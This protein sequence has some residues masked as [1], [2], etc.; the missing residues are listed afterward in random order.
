MCKSYSVK[1]LWTLWQKS[2]NHVC[3]TFLLHFVSFTDCSIVSVVQTYPPGVNRSDSTMK[4]LNLTHV[5]QM[6]K[7][8][9]KRK[10][11]SDIVPFAKRNSLSLQELIHVQCHIQINKADLN[12]LENPS[13]EKSRF[14][15]IVCLGGLHLFR[16]RTGSSNC[17]TNINWPGDLSE[18]SWINPLKAYEIGP[19]WLVNLS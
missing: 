3:S 7:P 16:K 18:Q 5:T 17:P 15:L 4:T 13:M 9:A 11:N 2:L 19:V 1:K 10:K 6:S 14:D 12:N 8:I